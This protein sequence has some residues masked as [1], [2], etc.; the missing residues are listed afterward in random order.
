MSTDDL[1]III[2]R[3]RK[4]AGITQEELAYRAEIHASYV[5]QLERG[6]KSPTVAVLT[7]IARAL[8][9]PTS[10]IIQAAERER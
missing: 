5:S 2:A 3:L 7:R 10:T 4:E 8:G 9:V 1:G 6:R